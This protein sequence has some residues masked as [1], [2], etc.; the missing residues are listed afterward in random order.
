MMGNFSNLERFFF[1][2]PHVTWSLGTRSALMEEEKV[3]AT[4]PDSSAEKQKMFWGG[5]NQRTRRRFHSYFLQPITIYL[6]LLISFSCVKT[7]HT[8]SPTRKDNFARNRNR[9]QTSADND[10]FPGCGH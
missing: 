9:G 6:I 2:H 4:S 10:L 3:G 1:L 7:D 5:S 8:D